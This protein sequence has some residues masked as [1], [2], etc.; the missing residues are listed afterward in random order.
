LNNNVTRGRRWRKSKEYIRCVFTKLRI[1]DGAQSAVIGDCLDLEGRLEIKTQRED[2]R[3][4]IGIGCASGKQYKNCS[5]IPTGII[6]AIHRRRI[7]AI[8]EV[9]TTS[10]VVNFCRVGR[11]NTEG[12]AIYIQN[13]GLKAAE[14]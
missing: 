1:I 10:C 8:G 9:T 12:N 3:Q 5:A 7:D 4:R 14:E 11:V 6:L 13:G 2:G